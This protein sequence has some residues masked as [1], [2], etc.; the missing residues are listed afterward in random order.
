MNKCLMIAAASVAAL[1]GMASG[2]VVLNEILRT[3]VSAATGV[4][5]T[6]FIGR[7]LSSVAWDG[8]D[9][10]VG[11]QSFDT[12]GSAIAK[13]TPQ[14]GTTN[15]LYQLSGSFGFQSTAGTRGVQD[16]DVRNGVLGVATDFGTNNVQGVRQFTTGGVAAGNS[17]FVN[18]GNGVSFDPTDGRLTALSI[19]QGRYF[20]FNGDTTSYNDGTRTW[21]STTGPLV[22]AAP[23]P[24]SGN[25]YRDIDHDST[26]NILFA[27]IQNGIVRANRNVGGTYDALTLLKSSGVD[28]VNGQNL[29][30]VPTSALYAP[31]LIYS[32]RLS[33][34]TGQSFT[35][36]VKAIDPTTGAAISLTFN[37]IQDAGFGNPLSSNGYYDFSY[38]AATQTLAV[39][40]FTNNTV[41]IFAVPAPSALALLGLGGLVAGRR[42]R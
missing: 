36:V 37:F 16:L 28:N 12:S 3:N 1:A 13:V 26:G 6:W 17:S 38:D 21:D 10:Y 39:S 22:G 24:L 18:R 40:D 2:Q 14:V 9:L 33:T 41:H 23:A 25:T 27:R 15:G 31:F 35:N 19:A 30:Y 8:T 4:G 29:E 20:K 42:R 5:N 32:D 7:N 34:A 11:G